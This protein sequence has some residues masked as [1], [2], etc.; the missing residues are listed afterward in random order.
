MQGIPG[1]PLGRKGDGDNPRW[2]SQCEF[3]RHDLKGEAGR[4]IPFGN[5]KSNGFLLG[6]GGG[7]LRG[8]LGRRGMV[9]VA[10]SEHDQHPCAQKQSLKKS[11]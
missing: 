5:D 4:D 1:I 2:R 6:R 10:G 9:S 7:R 11:F 8:N 3:P